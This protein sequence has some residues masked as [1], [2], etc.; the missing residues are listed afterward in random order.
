MWC[1]QRWSYVTH[2]GGT[3]SDCSLSAVTLRWQDA[4]ASISASTALFE[5]VV[6]I[7]KTFHHSTR[8]NADAIFNS[9]PLKHKPAS[10]L[11]SLKRDVIGTDGLFDISHEPP[12][13]VYFIPQVGLFKFKTPHSLWWRHTHVVVPIW[14]GMIYLLVFLNKCNGFWLTDVGKMAAACRVLRR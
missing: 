11:F 2:T 9:S 4:I 8:N 13:Q 6:K 14:S 3:V 1:Q 7:N 5:A 10:S 12:N